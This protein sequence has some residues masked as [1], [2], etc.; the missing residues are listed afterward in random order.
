MRFL[1]FLFR[2]F[3][4]KLAALFVAAIIWSYAVLERTHSVTLEL[5]VTQGRLPAGMVVAS[6]DTGRVKAQVSGKGRDLMLLR[7][8]QPAIRLNLTSENPGRV[9]VK[10]AQDQTNLP[11]SVQLVSARPEYVSVDLD[12]QSRRM[13][14]VTVPVRGK[15]PAGYVATSTRALENAWLTGPQEEI[16]LVATLLT[17]SLALAEFTGPAERKLRILTPEGKRF[18]IEP[19]SVNVAVRVEREETRVFPEV[20]LTIIKPAIHLVTVKPPNARVTVSGAAEAVRGLSLQ[21]IS[22]S[23][24]VT[25]TFPKGS[26]RM[27]CEIAL[28]TGIALVRCEPALFDVEIK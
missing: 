15:P 12:Q 16:G 4:L 28:P 21:S 10:L 13:V 2:D 1:R 20:A 26:R 23:L 24:K 18:R 3:S 14:K 9:R 25:D 5:P 6:I 11:A 17:E 27:P 19:D 8:R 7:L 22:A